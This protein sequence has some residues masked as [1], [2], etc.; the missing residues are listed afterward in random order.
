[1][2][3]MT[4]RRARWIA[5]EPHACAPPLC[6]DAV[7]A[8]CVF[9]SQT[10]LEFRY[11][12]RG[13]VEQL[14]LPAAPGGQ[15]R[16]GLWQHSCCEAFIS[17]GDGTYVELNFAPN[18]DWAA[19]HFSAYRKRGADP[20]MAAPAVRT[21]HGPGWFELAADVDVRPWLAV[22]AGKPLQISLAAVLEERADRCSYWA[23]RH[24]GERPD[25]HD[26]TGF[27]LQVTLAAS[28]VNC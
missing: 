25:F 12:I 7:S 1:M 16:D 27:T 10:M 26:A 28:A 4:D 21:Q 23:L 13:E 17:T 9:A 19:Y 14:P 11:R 3:A 6:V 15:R 24:A 20:V 22:E 18:G 8:S 2:R 5:L